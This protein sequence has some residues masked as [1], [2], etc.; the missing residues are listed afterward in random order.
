MLFAVSYVALQVGRN[1][2][3]ASLLRRDQPLRD[4]F[5]RLVGWSA[6]SG[7][8][9]LAGAA[10]P[11][12]R[13]LLLWIP[14]VVL[15]LCAPV[16][17]Y[18]LPRRGRAV[19]TDWDIEGGHFTDRCQGFIIIAL[20][21]SIV[22]TGATAAD[23]G[24]SSTV[25]LCLGIAFLET[26]ALWWLYFG[27]VAERSRLVMS[28]CEDPGRLARDAYT[29]LHVP[30]V[31][32]IIAVAVGDD[33]LIADPARALHGVGLAMVLG[34]PALY[35]VGESLFRLRVTG[36]AN[37][38]RLAVA[39][40]LVLLVPLGSQIS[41]LALSATVAA[42]LSA[43]ALWELR[44][45]AHAHGDPTGHADGRDPRAHGRPST[46]PTTT[47]RNVMKIVVIGGSGRVGSNVVRRLDAQGHD[48]VPASP[49]TGVDTI[50]GEGLADVMAGA[51]VVV[52]VSNAPV[53]D[54][55]AVLEFF[56][57]ST[58]NLLAAERD[59][60]VGH[61]LAVSI[62]GADRLP[63]SG[64]LRA[65]VAQEAEIE[66]G[67]V[68]YTILR[69]TQ[70]F[71]FLPQI[72]E[73]GAEGD[74]VR[75]PTGLMQL[76][77]ADDVAA[78][79][80]ELATGAPVGGRVELGGPEALGVDAWARRLFA[81]TGDERTVVGDPHARYFGTELHGGELTPGDGA[82]IGTIDFDTWFAT[83]RQE[84]AR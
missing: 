49:A 68:P 72:V 28:A 7:V 35:L 53:W 51:D 2:A 27:A 30:I 16:A 8:L 70:F 9:W 5:E 73:G 76:V 1:A 18:W 82:R 74:S 6:A 10:L 61:H 38:E 33:L 58:R 71:E 40:I 56:T 57:T 55:D 64:Y 39:A 32:G 65:K 47:G 29:Y 23:A 59:A 44:T 19:T 36:A 3:A 4:V 24:L 22:V 42:L 31:A 14:A 75:L 52:D 20:G 48:A 77:A 26:A 13:R 67:G 37:A 45:L 25:V 69:A 21:E 54:D 81:A 46:S 79:V 41:A 34:G 43:L 83:H 62:V 63:D 84:A 80:A 66:A 12:D 11:G 17:G 78:T 60:G 50:T 15:D